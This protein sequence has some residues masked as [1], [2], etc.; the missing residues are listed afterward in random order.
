VSETNKL[1]DVLAGLTRWYVASAAALGIE[2]VLWTLALT[3]ETPRHTS[4]KPRPNPMP[5]EPPADFGIPETRGGGSSS[6]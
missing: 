6:K 2:V 3:T 4:D 1:A 5:T